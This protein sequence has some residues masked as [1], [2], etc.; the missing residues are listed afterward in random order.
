M[1]ISIQSLS[2]KLNK[3]VDEA[4]V[5]KDLVLNIDTDCVS[6]CYNGQTIK[7]ITDRVD[8]GWAIQSGRIISDDTLLK[9]IRNVLSEAALPLFSSSK[10]YR[11]NPFSMG[12]GTLSPGVTVGQCSPNSTQ[13]NITP[14]HRLLFIDGTVQGSPV[15]TRRAAQAMV[16]AYL[17]NIAGDVPVINELLV[18]SQL[19]SGYSCIMAL[20]V[21]GDLTERAREYVKGEAIAY[22]ETLGEQSYSNYGKIAQIDYLIGTLS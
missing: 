9:E 14:L 2:K 22:R 10:S 15:V 11:P 20:C 7:H 21:A 3:F 12:A 4:G 5:G 1:K 16:G 18:I 8:G 13:Q 6:I 17:D 19:M